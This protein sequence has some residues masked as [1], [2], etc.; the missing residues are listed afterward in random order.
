MWSTAA[1]GDLDAAFDCADAVVAV[2]SQ[3]VHAN[4][5]TMALIA[6]ATSFHVR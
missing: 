6:I 2:T 4:T 1:E 3:I 5:P